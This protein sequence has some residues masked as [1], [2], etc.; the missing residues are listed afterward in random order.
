[1]IGIGVLWG[2]REDELMSNGVTLCSKTSFR[3]FRNSK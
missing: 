2:F 1:M 3:Y